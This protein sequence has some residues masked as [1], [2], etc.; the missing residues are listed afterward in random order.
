MHAV[1]FLFAVYSRSAGF[2]RALFARLRVFSVNSAQ[3][4]P[5]QRIFSLNPGKSAQMAIHLI[6]DTRPSVKK[7][8]GR[9]LCIFFCLI[10]SSIY[11]ICAI[12]YHIFAHRNQ[13]NRYYLD[14]TL[15]SPL[16]SSIGTV[17]VRLA[18]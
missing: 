9:E 12:H 18:M 1:R 2:I 7:H 11:G 3:T 6:K 15:Y 10:E 5:S 16:S 4:I 14:L 17:I 8:S 13:L